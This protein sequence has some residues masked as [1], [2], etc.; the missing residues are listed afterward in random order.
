MCRHAPDGEH[1]WDPLTWLE[2]CAWCGATRY[3]KRTS[4]QG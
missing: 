1:Q 2:I 3:M 4:I